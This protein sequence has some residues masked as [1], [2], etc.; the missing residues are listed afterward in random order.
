MT[1]LVVVDIK[2][3]AY[4]VYN[5]RTMVAYFELE[6]SELLTVAEIEA[7]RVEDYKSKA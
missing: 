4:S 1:K 6:E 3:N 7:L 2:N 5:N